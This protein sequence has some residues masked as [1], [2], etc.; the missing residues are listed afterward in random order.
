MD[1]YLKQT[2]VSL[3]LKAVSFCLTGVLLFFAERSF[4]GQEGAVQQVPYI[5]LIT[6]LFFALGLLGNMVFLG[7]ARKNSKYIMGYYL[8]FKVVR[9]L[10][11]V[12]LLVIYAIAVRHNLLAFA[13]N[14]LVLYVVEMVL[15][16]MHCTRMERKIQNK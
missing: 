8:L 5:I 13:V 15:S 6:T 2:V 9:L 14:V 10:L 4:M 11:A 7:L 12:V 16:I 3:V 1:R